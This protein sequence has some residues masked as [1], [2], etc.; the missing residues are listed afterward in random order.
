[1]NY[2]KLYLVRHYFVVKSNNHCVSANYGALE[3]YKNV[4]KIVD[5]PLIQEI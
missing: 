3:N 1:M 2:T 5:M 4:V